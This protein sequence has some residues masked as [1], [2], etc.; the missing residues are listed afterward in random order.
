MVEKFGS[1]LSD[2][3][4]CETELDWAI[5]SLSKGFHVLMLIF[6][7]FLL[8]FTSWISELFQYKPK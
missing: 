8:L 2:G 1:R 6:N 7:G 3:R 5:V 4:C